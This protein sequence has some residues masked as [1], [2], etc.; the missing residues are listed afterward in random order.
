MDS[1]V[2]ELLYQNRERYQG[3]VQLERDSTERVT[4]LR[5]DSILLDS[6]KAQMVEA[7]YGAVNELEQQTLEIPLGSILAPTLLSGKGPRIAVI[8][9]GLAFADAQFVSAFTAAGLNQTRHNI[10]LQL[11]A[12]LSV[13]AGWT[14]QTVSLDSPFVLT[15]TVIVG[16][17]PEHYSYIEDST[18]GILGEVSDLEENMD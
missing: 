12:E 15:D 17:V 2:T 9:D 7:V 4:A 16:T 5:T 8:C 13:R 14:R 18:K 1:V 10:I 3:L 11:H 6:I